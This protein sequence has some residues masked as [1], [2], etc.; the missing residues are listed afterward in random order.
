MV[1]DPFPP[2][3]YGPTKKLCRAKVPEASLARRSLTPALFLSDRNA[4]ALGRLQLFQQNVRL[5]QI[6][7]V[8]AFRKPAADRSEQFASLLRLALITP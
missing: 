3:Y 1:S 2:T 8:K 5:L 7:R 4:G 6:A